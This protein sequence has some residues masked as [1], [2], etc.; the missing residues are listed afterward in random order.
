MD[1]KGQVTLGN[2]PMIVMIVGL[3]FILMATVALVSEK[4]GEALP[5]G[6]SGS[7]VNETITSVNQLEAIFLLFQNQ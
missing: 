6:E 7:V 4:Y 1:K 3:V 2:A 5:A